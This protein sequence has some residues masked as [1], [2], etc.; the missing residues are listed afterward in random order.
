M[1][2]Q[3]LPTDT[4]PLVVVEA[5]SEPD[6]K[7]L[8][9][10]AVQSGLADPREIARWIASQLPDEGLR[11]VLGEVLR[12]WVMNLTRLEQRDKPRRHAQG[13][14]GMSRWE[15]E[16]GDIAIYARLECPNGEWKQLG[17]CSRAEVQMLGKSR[18][19]SAM[20]H[21]REAGRFGLLSKTMGER[22]ATVV[23]DLPV[24]V[25][26]EILNA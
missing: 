17:D 20:S 19:K 26:V 3:A 6:L 7:A 25:V 15:R 4:R 12:P 8:W 16:S 11:D 2:A 13:E 9:L 18:L 22:N 14:A 1:S 23:R 24:D 21:K 5:P 10:E